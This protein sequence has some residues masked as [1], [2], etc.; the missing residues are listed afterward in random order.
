[1]ERTL[2]RTNGLKPLQKISKGLQKI[3]ESIQKTPKASQKI[4]VSGKRARSAGGW[5]ED[6]KLPQNFRKFQENQA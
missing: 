1:M 4:T 5:D 3:P 2:R 6:R